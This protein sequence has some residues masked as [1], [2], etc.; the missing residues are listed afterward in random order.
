MGQNGSNFTR[1]T[2]AMLRAYKVFLATA[3]PQRKLVRTMKRLFACLALCASLSASAQ[4]DNCTVLGVQEL[5]LLYSELSASIDTIVAALQLNAQA[6][7][8]R[9]IIEYSYCEA[10]SNTGNYIGSWMS[11]IQ[12]CCNTRLSQGFQPF[13]PVQIGNPG[14]VQVF[15]KYAD[16]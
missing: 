16:D 14:L 10:G 5:S 13:G 4:D 2:P 12:P 15:V 11:H 3:Y 7:Q 6:Q 1:V 8:P 9:T